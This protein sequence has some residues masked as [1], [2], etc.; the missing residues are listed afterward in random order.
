MNYANSDNLRA[1][2]RML[3]QD[4]GQ[5]PTSHK[6]SESEIDSALTDGYGMVTYGDRNES[7]ASSFDTALAK[8]YAGAQLCIGLARDRARL[9]AWRSAAGEGVESQ[10][11]AIRLE[12]LANSW[13][14]QVNTALN[15]LIQ[16]SKNDVSNV[17]HAEGANMGLNGATELTHSEFR[18]GRVNKLNRPNDR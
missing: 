4:Y 12:S 17:A 14:N 6:W 1:Q 9:K 3:V 8:M 13:M 10:Q 16:K 15:R 2:L 18:F 5:D 7:T 11:E